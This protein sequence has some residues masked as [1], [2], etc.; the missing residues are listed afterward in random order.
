MARRSAFTSNTPFVRRAFTRF[1]LGGVVAQAIP[2]AWLRILGP[3]GGAPQILDPVEG[4]NQTLAAFIR[5]SNV[6][7]VRVADILKENESGRIFVVRQVQP[8][9]NRTDLL[10]C[11]EIQAPIPDEFDAQSLEPFW[12]QTDTGFSIS[13]DGPSESVLLLSTMPAGTLPSSAKGN[14]QLVA[15][16]FDV[17]AQLRTD[18]G[19]AGNVRHALLGARH[20]TSNLGCYVGVRSP[21]A[22]TADTVRLDE[23]AVATLDTTTGTVGAAAVTL[24]FARLKRTGSRFQAFYKITPN[25]PI[26]ESDWIEIVNDPATSFSSVED[27]RV[28]LWGYTDNST[29]GQ[30]IFA[31]LRN[32]PEAG[33]TAAGAGGAEIGEAVV[34]GTVGSVLFVGPGPALNQDNANLFWDD[35]NNRLGVRTTTP[36]ARQTIHAAPGD[37]LSG[38][39]LHVGVAAS[40]LTSGQQAVLADAALRV[41]TKNSEFGGGSTGL[42]V[43][44]TSNLQDDFIGGAFIVGESRQTVGTDGQSLGALIVGVADGGAVSVSLI[45]GISVFAEDFGSGTVGA[46]VPLDVNMTVDKGGGDVIGGAFIR[47]AENSFHNDSPDFTDLF[48]IQINSLGDFTATNKFAIQ[49]NGPE[50]VRFGGRLDVGIPANGSRAASEVSLKVSSPASPTADIAQFTVNGVTTAGTYAGVTKGGTV[51]TPRNVVTGTGTVNLDF[52]LGNIQQFT[53]GAGNATF[54][55]TNIPNSALITIVIIQDGV[56]SRTLTWPATAKFIGGTAP[57]LSV[58]ANARDIIQF[59]SDGTNIY[60]VSAIALAVA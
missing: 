9:P 47:I 30:A 33:A 11:V 31:F 49:T 32:W 37:S 21:T 53:F 45:R 13:S 59:Y 3:I 36:L 26:A 46:I 7:G 55:F 20:P 51:I 6:F 17:W 5:L 22:T 43:L 48:G 58:G 18:A 1:R 10:H 23:H 42:S 41:V 34:G 16:D 24:F 40:E 44:N 27:L 8:E 19:A 57:T 25:T 28:G 54:T 50:L 52:S 14:Y 38:G 2:R 39:F 60:Q 35:G 56:G 29:A 4:E 15:G 12:T